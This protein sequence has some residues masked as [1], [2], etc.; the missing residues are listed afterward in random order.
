MKGLGLG[1]G[2]W[3]RWGILATPVK[4][5]IGFRAQLQGDKAMTWKGIGRS[6]LIAVCGLLL[7]L[8]TWVAWAQDG[9]DDRWDAEYD[10]SMG[11]LMVYLHHTDPVSIGLSITRPDPEENDETEAIAATLAQSLPCQA[12]S[13]VDSWDGWQ[14]IDIWCDRDWVAQQQR[15]ELTLDLADLTV[16]LQQLGVES[17][18]LGVHGQ[19]MG[20]LTVE[21]ALSEVMRIRT[22][23]SHQDTVAVE[24]LP[25]R[26]LVRMGYAPLGLALRGLGAIA[27]LVW[28]MAVVWLMRRRAL[29]VQRG[30]E[31]SEG[32]GAAV[33]FSYQY[34]LGMVNIAVWLGWVAV[35]LSMDGLAIAQTL[36]PMLGHLGGVLVLTVVPP[37][38]VNLL[39]YALSHPVFVRVG[40]MDWTMGDLMQQCLWGQLQVLLPLV[41]VMLGFQSIMVGSMQV[42]VLVLLGA[43]ASRMLLVHWWV[44]SQDLTVQALTMG[45]LRDRIF[46]LAKP[47]GVNLSQVYVLPQ[48]R[49]RMVNAFALQDDRVIFSQSLLEQLT[50]DEVDAV[51]AHELAH[52]QYKHHQSLQTA[53]I[54]AAVITGLVT[55]TVAVW[56]PSLP[57]ILVTIGVAVIVYHVTSRRNEHQADIQAVLLTGKPRAMITALAKLAQF[58]QLPLDW[59]KGQ[60]WLLTHPSMRRRAIAIAS[61]YDVAVD[62]V[63]TWLNQPSLA[64]GEGY[65]LPRAVVDRQVIFSSEF[66]QGVVQRLSWGLLLTLTL[67]PTGVAAAVQYGDVTGH[68]AVLALGVG[69][70]ATW[71]LMLALINWLPLMGHRR[72]VAQLRERLGM[73][74]MPGLVVGLA[75][76][77]N[78]RIYEGFYN[79]DM[80]LLWLVGDRLCYRGEQTEFS[81]TVAQVTQL[82]RRPGVQGWWRSPRIGIY[83]QA[84]EQAGVFTLVPVEVGSL[85]Q[86]SGAVR[87]LQ[88]QMEDWWAH[89]SAE[90]CPDGLARLPVPGWGPVTSQGLGEVVTVNLFISSAVIQGAIAVGL[91]LLA[92]LPWAGATV[93]YIAGVAWMGSLIQ[94]IPLWRARMRLSRDGA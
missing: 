8:G 1:D 90:P 35:L 43:I 58:N 87:Q 41:L 61:R 80:G 68:W 73:E 17:V 50:R 21:P 2:F 47:T 44:K 70:I 37:L 39:C 36:M 79:W 91:T 27:L 18:M 33:W 3:G 55:S 16:P 34:W 53:W 75:P 15:W 23:V 52:L 85:R 10:Q 71:G 94:L 28:P 74:G 64:D 81:L 5:G 88:R 49:N 32:I 54:G 82:Q 38:G 56:I 7:G 22:V 67:V 13:A 84:G 93:G 66:K 89:P 62:Q 31:L 78:P 57:W 46:A 76:D 24:A 45:D 11:T 65:D 9:L 20:Q 48:G 51:V 4:L 12:D 72:L 40:R 19:P 14:T 26:L 83:W 59:G 25:S 77:A 60:E 92:G 86:I 30:A 63:E 42:G 6:L 69:A 29:Q